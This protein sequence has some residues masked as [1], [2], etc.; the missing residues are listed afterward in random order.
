MRTQGANSHRCWRSIAWWN[1]KGNALSYLYLPNKKSK[2]VCFCSERCAACSFILNAS[3][4]VKSDEEAEMQG[5]A[6]WNKRGGQFCYFCYSSLVVT[7]ASYAS[8]GLGA[9]NDKIMTHWCVALALHSLQLRTKFFMR[10]ACAHT[11]FSP[12]QH[13]LGRVLFVRA[14]NVRFVESTDI[15]WRSGFLSLFSHSL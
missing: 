6:S 11:Q 15:A 7:G 14:E 8:A 5:K 1:L 10:N 13:T 2:H 9:S 3:A 4:Q 12:V